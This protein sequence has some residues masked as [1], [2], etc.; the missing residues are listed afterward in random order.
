[1]LKNIGPLILNGRFLTVQRRKE[2]TAPTEPKGTEAERKRVAKL[3]GRKK[4]GNELQV[5]TSPYGSTQ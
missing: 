1:M 2:I 4:Q 5:T 3:R